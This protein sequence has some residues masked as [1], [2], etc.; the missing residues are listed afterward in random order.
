MMEVCENVKG[1]IIP[2]GD[3]NSPKRGIFSSMC[4]RV[5][6][7]STHSGVYYIARTL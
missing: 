3:I 1:K 7:V 6:E 4:C 5:M 2:I